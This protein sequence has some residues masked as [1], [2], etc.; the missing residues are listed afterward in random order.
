MENRKSRQSEYGVQ[1]Q[2]G[3]VRRRVRMLVGMYGLGWLLA[4]LTG[5]AAG[6]VAVD[7]L[8]NLRAWPRVVLMVVAGL[9]IV[10]AAWKYLLK[11][12]FSKLTLSDVAGRV[13]SHFPEFEDRLRSVIEFER[14]PAEGVESDHLRAKVMEEAGR[15]I[16]GKD[17][18]SAIDGQPAKRRILAGLC[19]VAAFTA[20]TWII[21]TEYRIAAVERLS[22]PFANTPWPK[23]TNIAVV[24]DLPTRVPAGE[25][26]PV[27]ARLTKGDRPSARATV[28]YQYGTGPV[29]SELM[30]RGE[31]GTY[32]A[33]LDARLENDASAGDVRIWVKAGD[34]E[35]AVGSL[36]VV[37]RLAV[38]RIVA[39]VVV[40]DYARAARG[41]SQGGAQG[42]PEY[43]LSKGGIGVV[44]GSG[45]RVKLEFNKPLAA[46]PELVTVGEATAPVGAKGTIAESRAELAFEPEKSLRFRVAA[47][48]Q[49]GFGV[50]AVSEYEVLV[51][52]DQNPSIQIEMPRRNE[53]RTAVASV[54]LQAVGED[55]FAISSVVLKVRRIGDGRAWE[56]P[57]V[58]E[59]KAVATTSGTPDWSE[60]NSA[61]ERV[62]MKM[63]YLWELSKLENANLQPGDV[64][65]YFL[66]AKDNYRRSVAGRTLEH[67][68]VT[69]SRLRIVIVSQ[70]QLAAKVTEELRGAA[71]QVTR[72]R[73]NQQRTSSETQ[74]LADETKNASQFDD[75]QKNQ[76]KR[77]ADQQSVV[78]SQSKQIAGKLEDLIARM[79][80]N[81]MEA[82]ELPETARDVK[83]LLDRAA[84]G[85]MKQATGD[86]N[87]SR[88]A[89][90]QQR[91]QEMAE[92]RESQQ[93]ADRML[94]QAQDR[95]SSL[96]SVRQTMENL[97]NLL[98]DQQ[99]LGNQTRELG[100]NNLGKRPEEMSA[101]DRKKLEELAKQQSELAKRSESLIQQMQDQAGQMEKSDPQSSEAM[102][103]AAQQGQQQGVPQAQ[104][105]ASQSMEQN[106]QTQAQSQQRQAEIGL[107]TMLNQLQ[108]AEKRK[109][110]E[111]NKKL[112]DLQ[113][114]IQTLVRRQAG[115]NL[116][117]LG[118]REAFAKLDEQTKARL[119][120]L[121][122]REKGKETGGDL[123]SLS[124][125]QEQTERNTRSLSEQAASVQNGGSGTAEVADHLSRAASRMER[126]AVLIRNKDLAASYEPPQVEALASLVSAL[127]KIEDMRKEAEEQA[128]Q[129][130]RETIRQA[131]TE[132]KA[133][134][135]QIQKETARL[136][137][138][139]A[140]AGDNL[141]RQELQKLTQLPTQQDTLAQ[142]TAKLEE[143]LVS[144]GAVVY[145]WA[146]KDIVESMSGVKTDL[147]ARNTSKPTQA[148]QSRVIEQLDAM[149]NSL[150]IKPPDKKEFEDRQANSGGGQ[151]Q[152]Q[153]QQRQRL[154]SEAELKLLRELQ[155]AV[156]RGTNAAGQA[157]PADPKAVERLAQRQADLRKLLGDL[158][159]KASR[160]QFEL[161]PEPK[162]EV[163]MPEEVT[164]A[165]DANDQF[166]QDL[167]EGKPHGED[168]NPKSASAVDR[169]GRSRQRLGEDKDPGPITQKIQD[170]I[171]LDIDDLIQ[172]ARQQQQQQQSSSRSRSRQQQQG[173]Q[174]PGSE[175]ANNQGNQ[176][177]GQQQ[178][179]NNQ[180]GSAGANQESVQSGSHKD[181]T[182]DGGELAGRMAEWGG[183]TPR[184]RQ[185]IVEG[186]QDSPLE[187]YRGLIEDYYRS[188]A[189]KSSPP[190]N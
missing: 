123:A 106:Q 163:K 119:A 24:S 121:S 120:D 151:G 186:S 70:D 82:K 88:D 39:E 179:P 166:D 51:R 8:L 30:S 66:E 49:D 40:P 104:Q 165:K 33:S 35:K 42:N 92:A 168:A 173:Q 9:G 68:P 21:P 161:G 46:L 55:D 94:G 27:R 10:T 105:K 114:Q 171:L 175:Q 3:A 149:I 74:D 31:D 65:E 83:N 147:A 75:A 64:L 180:K 56:I 130:Q 76:V 189:E 53:E 86:L 132:I 184:Q 63:M 124:T 67:S 140:R 176:P 144:V 91:Q 54:P 167:L 111:L 150:T 154:P 34:D 20:A 60:A 107:Q 57:L 117:N 1:R 99:K 136:D 84:E 113:E 19:C 162:R 37:P 7:Y 2:L 81:R 36:A 5:V 77:L 158:L 4:A 174:Q 85:P 15:M 157:N 172:Q 48:D 190:K 187:K 109:L 71:E 185:A 137:A 178:G 145:V 69:S 169:M 59:G 135:E 102:K 80:E 101:T 152:G 103:Q 170:R 183:V 95:L 182:K 44:E 43:D 128:Q 108:E 160:G 122:E 153:Q 177:N 14:R 52:P 131:Y 181:P 116:D 139:K 126:A 47:V 112:A 100:K 41:G 156:N 18:T 164:D 25:R 61:P 50:S 125:G 38:K 110:E 89:K 143:D 13:E 78:A 129:K 134:Q 148:E 73:T 146:N 159:N 72:L 98:A 6:V 97:K 155:N 17:L 32:T 96:G 133:E 188:L 22:A 118:L 26:I 115:H 141:P 90:D 58:A 79:A 62:R 93:Q 138:L 16:L 11:P 29:R 28:F 23:R 142:R 127:T 12:L 87:Q 45:V